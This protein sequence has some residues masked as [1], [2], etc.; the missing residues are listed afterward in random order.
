MSDHKVIGYVSMRLDKT[1][2]LTDGPACVIAGS[3]EYM[4]KYISTEEPGS[5][6]E[7]KIKKTRLWEI[8]KGIEL[9]AEYQ[10]DDISYA[11]FKEAAKNNSCFSKLKIIE[12]QKKYYNQKF[13]NV[14]LV[15]N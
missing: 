15:K 11:R 7:Q 2:I 4:K 8:I 9:G 14:V 5:L 12:K 1:G 3:D 6:E 13:Y 10:F